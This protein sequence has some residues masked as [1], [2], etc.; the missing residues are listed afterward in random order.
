MT[1]MHKKITRSWFR[2][3]RV[4]GSNHQHSVLKIIAVYFLTPK[5]HENKLPVV[6][7]MLE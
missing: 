4:A 7:P 3:V 1:F 5:E 2:E 6:E